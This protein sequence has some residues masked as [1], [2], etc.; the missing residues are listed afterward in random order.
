MTGR[1]LLARNK[2]KTFKTICMLYLELRDQNPFPKHNNRGG[3]TQ[4]PT[5]YTGTRE[6]NDTART[7]QHSN[8][9]KVSGSL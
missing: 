8:E 4:K 2:L 3:I 1:L 5:T 7:K 6:K 9:R